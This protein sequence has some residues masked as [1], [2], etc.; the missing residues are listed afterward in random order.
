MATDQ[1][2]NGKKLTKEQER[3]RK[4]KALDEATKKKTSSEKGKASSKEKKSEVG[5]RRILPIWLRLLI[6]LVLSAAALL[7]GVMVGYGVIGDGK[8]MDALN[9]ETWQ[10]IIDIVTKTE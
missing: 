5:R 3:E 1:N 6:V 4:R 10:H 7:L 8:P 2:P 9:W